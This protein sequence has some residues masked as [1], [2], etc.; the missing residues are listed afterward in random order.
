LTK[1]ELRQTSDGVKGGRLEDMKGGMLDS[2][3]EPQKLDVSKLVP[4]VTKQYDWLMD[5]ERKLDTSRC[6]TTRG[7]TSCRCG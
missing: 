2:E 7:S 5:V 6:G 1:D 4:P 3:L